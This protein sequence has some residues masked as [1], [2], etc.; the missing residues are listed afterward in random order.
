[1]KA[2]AGDCWVKATVELPNVSEH[3]EIKR[4]MDKPNNLVCDEGYTDVLGPIQELAIRGQ[5]VLTQREILNYVTADA[6]TIAKQ[7]QN[8][9]RINYLEKT[10]GKLGKIKIH[11]KKIFKKRKL[12][13]TPV[14]LI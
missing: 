8:L 4:V 3:V 6:G 12:I 14:K 5:H 9:L 10:R 11:L 2:E 7:I 1:M 13:S